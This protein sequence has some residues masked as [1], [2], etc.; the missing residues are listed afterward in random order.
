[1]SSPAAD[2][3]ARSVA[4]VA[5]RTGRS[6][7]AIRAMRRLEFTLTRA[8]ARLEDR[9][10]ELAEIRSLLDELMTHLHDDTGGRRVI[11]RIELIPGELGRDVAADLVDEAET[12]LR[13]SLLTVEFGPALENSSVRQVRK[14]L[15]EGL[16]QR[17]LYP[18]DVLDS[19]VGRR[20]VES[21]RDAGE[22]QRFT[23]A[24]P[25][26]CL[27]S[28]ETAVLAAAAWEQPIGDYYLIREPMLVTAFARL[29][30]AS[31]ELGTAFATGESDD[32]A[33]LLAL[34]SIGIKDEAI[35]RSLG[36]GVRTVRRRVAALMAEFNVETRFQLGAAAQ[37]LG[38]LPSR[39]TP[40]PRPPV[41]P[42]LTR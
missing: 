13:N 6:G 2:G 1:M 15:A 25:S 37:E 41:P 42:R 32:T 4:A 20:W 22:E 3:S 12:I 40:R 31:W 7:D 14:R 11:S 33:K 26:E 35:A 19:P 23:T 38:L 27:V 9:R 10:G 17:S 36:W 24:P 18:I 34:M 39:L 30:D 29:F 8:E 21:W 5:D 16:V 28:D